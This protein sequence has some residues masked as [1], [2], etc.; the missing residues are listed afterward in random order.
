MVSSGSKNERLSTNEFV[1]RQ[2]TIFQKII[3]VNHRTAIFAIV[4][5]FN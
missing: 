3:S 2:T 5:N 4:F 1:H